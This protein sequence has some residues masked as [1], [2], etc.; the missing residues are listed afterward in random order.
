MHIPSGIITVTSGE[1]QE[2]I[3]DPEIAELEKIPKFEPLIKPHHPEIGLF[4]VLW[5]SSSNSQ[6]L[7]KELMD[8]VKSVDDYCADISKSMISTQLQAKNNQE[9]IGIGN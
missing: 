4:N 7:D 9:Q 5:G 8:T 2:E 6:E 3:L 1:N